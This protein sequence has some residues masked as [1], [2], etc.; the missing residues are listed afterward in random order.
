MT[1]AVA[2]R[3]AFEA[4]GPVEADGVAAEAGASDAD[5]GATEGVD[6][7]DGTTDEIELGVTEETLLGVSE[8]GV[9]D[10]ES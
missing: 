9:A 2:V 8:D 1:V 4:E 3:V 5:E 7:A 6:E 10:A